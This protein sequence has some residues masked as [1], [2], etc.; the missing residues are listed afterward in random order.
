MTSNI[1]ALSTA[2]PTTSI[3]QEE[4][5]NQ[6]CASLNLKGRRKEFLH[7][8]YQNSGISKR[9]TIFHPHPSDSFFQKLFSDPSAGMSERNEMYRREA[10]KL[11]S[12][13]ATEAIENWGGDK[14]DI[15]HIISVTC[16]GT[17]TPGIEFIVSQELGLSPNISRLGINFIGCFGAFKG[18]EMAHAICQSNPSHRVLLVCTELTSLHLQTDL[19]ADTLISQKL[20]F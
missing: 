2:I 18:L 5:A 9:H 8:I 19:K 14:A 10:P 15:T 12:Q 7:Q 4:I 3:S 6:M 20:D 11:A 13:A 1:L 16:T 17:I